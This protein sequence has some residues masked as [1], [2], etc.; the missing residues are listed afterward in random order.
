MSFDLQERSDQGGAPVQI[1]RFTIGA[2][3]RRYTSAD[4]DQV[5]DGEI[6]TSIALQI[7]KLEATPEMVRNSIQITLP[8]TN[9]IAEYYRITPPSTVIALTISRFH[10]TDDATELAVEWIGRVV[11]CRFS[12]PTAEMLCEPV[13]TSARRNGLGDVYSINCPYPFGGPDCGVDR[14][15]FGVTT[16]IGTVNGLLVTVT[17]LDPA[18][19]WAGGDVIWMDGEGLPQTRYID[20]FDGDVELTLTI[21]FQG[22][23]PGASVLVRPACRQTTADC[24][25]YGNQPNYGGEPLIPTQNPFDG[26]PVY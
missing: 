14:N 2:L 18:R 15:S 6:Y 3:E 19:S 11:N 8:R 26:N 21:P 7:P 9:P 22:I 5:I 20:A 23:A 13:S 12:G 4:V 17:G 1:V 16:S 24:E 10:R 25:S